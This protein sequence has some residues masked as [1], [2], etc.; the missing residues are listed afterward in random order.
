MAA[1]RSDGPGRRYA[2]AV[3]VRR[4]R[5]YAFRN[6]T[7]P[8]VAFDPGVTAIVGPN[9]AG[10]SN[11]LDACYLAASADLPTGPVRDAL[12]FGEPEGFVA[13]EIENRHGV[14]RIHVGLAVGRKA[15]EVDGQKA[16]TADVARVAA[17]VRITP[18]DAELIHGGPTGRR[19]W[20][21]ALLT[22]LSP[23]YGALTRAYGKVLEQR[24]AALRHG[25]DGA[26]TAAFG[27]RLAALG[28]EMVDLRRRLIARAG[29]LA[30]D[31]Y[32]DVAGPDKEFSVRYAPS[33][34]ERALAEALAASEPEERARGVTVVGPHRDDLL[35]ELDARSVQTYGS[36]G[37]ARTAALALRVA[38]H[39][40][41]H[42]V[43]EE[44]PVL[45]L[46]DFSAELDVD[47]R[48]FL[49]DLAENAPQALVTGTE[50]PPRSARVLR[51]SA[52]EVRDDG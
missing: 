37:E 33:Q 1:D 41:L 42:D 50:P 7:V 11:L 31:A 9:A 39:R 13:A 44:P 5:Q 47:R 4:L 14:V 23:R 17:A 25:A 24:N 22:R 2:G 3:I 16:R 29:E 28:D 30:R 18:E 52:G 40:L 21:D 49:L 8:E 10:K 27:D 38:E 48:A 34:G 32:R 36:R 26:T 45:L 15:L 43:H 19:G 35:T 6:L 12:R 46:D 51:I 20:M